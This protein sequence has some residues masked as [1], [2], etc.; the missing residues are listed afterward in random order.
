MREMVRISCCCKNNNAK[1]KNSDY[2]KH[3]NDSCQTM[4][5]KLAIYCAH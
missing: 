4:E 5:M 2:D 1:Q 3:Q